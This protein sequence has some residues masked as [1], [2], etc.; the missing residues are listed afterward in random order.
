E[1]CYEDYE[2][3]LKS[4]N[5]R[6][7]KQA[8]PAFCVLDSSTEEMP[9]RRCGCWVCETLQ[10]T[11]LQRTPVFVPLGYRHLRRTFYALGTGMS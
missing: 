5:A 10:A 9:P 3:V 11:S 1:S 4:I 6:P 8:Q 2:H 7:T